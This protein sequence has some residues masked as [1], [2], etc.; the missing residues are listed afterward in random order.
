MSEPGEGFYARRLKRGLDLAGAALLMGQSYELSP[1]YLAG[2][3]LCLLSGILYTCYLIL[4]DRARGTLQP[5][6]DGDQ[7]LHSHTVKI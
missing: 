4:I 1:Q 5:L 6:G 7:S 2:D 3:L